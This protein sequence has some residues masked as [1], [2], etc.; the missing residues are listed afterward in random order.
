MEETPVRTYSEAQVRQ[1]TGGFSI[2]TRGTNADLFISPFS[3]TPNGI[4]SPAL[5]S[6]E[7]RSITTGFYSPQL[8]FATP[9]Y[10]VERKTPRSADPTRSPA[11]SKSPSH[12]LKPRADDDTALPMSELHISR[13]QSVERA[14]NEQ[15]SSLATATKDLRSRT[16]EDLQRRK[17]ELNVIEQQTEAE[18]AAREAAHDRELEQRL[19]KLRLHAERQH[20]LADQHLSELIRQKEAEEAER[21]RREAEAAAAAQR[22]REEAERKRREEEAKAAAEAARRKAEADAAAAAELKRKQEEEARR[23]AAA[24]ELQKR[25]QEQQGAPPAV[26]TPAAAAAPT[27][28]Q[29]GGG[30]AKASAPAAAA[31]KGGA[32]A[33]SSDAISGSARMNALKMKALF[34]VAEQSIAAMETHPRRR[35]IYKTIHLNC[36]QITNMKSQIQAKI[37]TLGQLLNASK[38]GSELEYRYCLA[39]ISQKLVDQ[40]DILICRQPA[41]AWGVAHTLVPLAAHHPILME[42]VIATFYNKCPYTVP[43]YPKRAALPDGTMESEEDFVY[44]KLKYKKKEDGKETDEAYF[45]R[46]SGYL[47]L[48]SAIT[49]VPVNNHPHGIEEAWTWLA[50][51]LNMPPRRATAHVLLAVLKNTGYSLVRTYGVQFRKLLGFIKSGYG[52]QLPA[53][54]PTDRAAKARLEIYI[55]D[56]E[57]A[58]GQIAAPEGYTPTND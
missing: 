43:C 36:N 11:A 18:L 16:Q 10:V 14:V 29:L 27:G 23:K 57:S 17:L 3:I 46:M 26:P 5:S 21:R 4:A 52:A 19:Q 30:I 9:E 34:Q 39:L 35:D 47:Y 45:E 28:T 42:F 8:S 53:D 48:Y 37:N 31:V 40:C 32:V 51:V 13:R 2:D 20:T 54:T 22:A 38:T 33:S 1:D 58:N 15:I 24:E 49:C 56:Y 7:P 55:S 44:K 41:S 25:Q 12:R 50:R 6:T